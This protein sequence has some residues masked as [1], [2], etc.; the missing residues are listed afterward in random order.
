[1]RGNLKVNA[2]HDNP[3]YIVAEHQVDSETVMTYTSSLLLTDLYMLTML[4]GFYK[5][6]VNGTASYEFSVRKLPDSRGFLVAAGLEQ[7]LEYL[8]E[9]R[10]NPEELEWLRHCGRFSPEFID[11]LAEWRFTG[12]VDAMPEGTVSFAN[13]PILRVTA[14]IS[15]AQLV[16]SRLINLLNLQTM[17]ASKAA[18]CVLAGG[19]RLLVDFG[20][21]RAHGAEAG[22]L[23]SRASYLAGFDGTAT[24]LAG[25]MFAIPVYGTMAHAYVQAHDSERAAFESFARA[26]PGNVVLLIDTYD[27]EEGARVVA[28]LAP[29]LHQSGINIK[30]VRLDSGDLAVHARNVRMI[31]DV[32]GLKDIGIFCSGNLDEYRLRDLVNGGAPIDGFGIG[33]RLD[34]SEDAPSLECVY[35]LVEYNGQPKRKRSEGK[36]TWPGRKQVFRQYRDDGVMETDTVSVW[37]D[38]QPGEQLLE[39]ILRQGKRVRPAESLSTIR[40][41]SAYQLGRLPGY[42]RALETQPVYPV[43]IAPAL[44]ELAKSADEAIGRGKLSE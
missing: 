35:K 17:I 26:Q 4:E 23:A 20:L 25:M 30:A 3:K 28:E 37:G 9:A 44:E 33:T 27:T 7:V 5:Q 16:E 38:L 12:D 29:R 14:P 40:E 34:T 2:C 41:R 32:A 42:F 13:E 8:E 1:M 19:Q 24:V 31:L 18:R 21:R 11:H 43:R 36:A 39:P 6:S 15:Q 10:F 22:L